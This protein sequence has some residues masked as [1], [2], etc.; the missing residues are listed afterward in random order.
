[1]LDEVPMDFLKQYVIKNRFENPR[2]ILARLNGSSNSMELMMNFIPD[3]HDEW[4]NDQDL[5]QATMAFGEGLRDFYA[6]LLPGSSKF[7]YKTKEVVYVKD[8]RHMELERPMTER[9]LKKY[10]KKIEETQQVKVAK[11]L[12]AKNEL[13]N[14]LFRHGDNL[15]EVFEDGLQFSFVYMKDHVTRPYIKIWKTE[16]GSYDF[17]LDVS[18]YSSP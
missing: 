1:M 17:W 18:D 4:P 14:L 11:I 9:E 8:G 15:L 16:N 3:I 2:N 5:C 10:G 12:I 6:T 13:G 7:I